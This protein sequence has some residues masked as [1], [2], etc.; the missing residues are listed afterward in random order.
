MAGGP[1]N[2]DATGY[3]DALARFKR[4]RGDQRMLVKH[5]LSALLRDSQRD[6]DEA[7]NRL[8]QERQ[9]IAIDR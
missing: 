6:P 9:S 7:E 4:D 5:V 3:I 8:W 2:S 1:T